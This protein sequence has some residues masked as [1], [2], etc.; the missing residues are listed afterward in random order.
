MK[1]GGQPGRRT[2][3]MTQTG[4][5]K[6]GAP[7][8]LE[9]RRP[10]VPMEHRPSPVDGAHLHHV[11]QRPRSRVL[12]H[13]NRR[14]LPPVF[15]NAFPPRGLSGLVRQAAYAV[16]EHQSKHWLLLMAAD[17]IERLGH[18]LGRTATLPVYVAVALAGV[19]LAGRRLVRA[20]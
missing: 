20:H 19:L 10:G 16:P 12:R 2:M 15:S 18:A 14:K 1:R 17:R 3:E 9:E 13:T 4:T 5:G 8:I 11:E 7:D 6:D